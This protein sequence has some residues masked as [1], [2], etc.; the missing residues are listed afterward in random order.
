MFDSPLHCLSLS[1]SPFVVCRVWNT[2]ISHPVSARCK[3][4]LVI[5]WVCALVWF[6][7]GEKQFDNFVFRMWLLKSCWWSKERM[8][9][10]FRK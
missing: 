4:L 3:K 6:G 2:R 10:I 5:E 1:P 9:Q 8:L 7:G